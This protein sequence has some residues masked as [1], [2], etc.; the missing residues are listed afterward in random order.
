ML[1]VPMTLTGDRTLDRWPR[2]CAAGNVGSVVVRRIIDRE[3]PDL[4]LCGHIHEAR[5]VDK[6]GR[7][8]IANPGP[9][10]AGHYAAVAVDGELS[11]RLDGDK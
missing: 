7:T 2:G 3:Q 8:R 10:A 5:A 4:V 11:V 1:A 6:I 9:V